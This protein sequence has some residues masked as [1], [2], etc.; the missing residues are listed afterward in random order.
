MLEEGEKGEKGE[1]VAGPT[2]SAISQSHNR[3]QS[4]VHDSQSTPGARRG[5]YVEHRKPA[6]MDWGG[7]KVTG[8]AAEWSQHASRS[9]P[10]PVS[11]IANSQLTKNPAHRWLQS[12]IEMAGGE[13]VTKMAACF[14]LLPS[15]SPC[16]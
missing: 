12:Q 9:V 1:K 10:V 15:A 8:P 11:A 5:R 4:K 3:S 16:F 7:V 13:L 2:T 6:S 14:P